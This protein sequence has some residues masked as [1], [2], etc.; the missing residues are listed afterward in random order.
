VVVMMQL[1]PFYDEQAMSLLAGVEE[2]VCR[3]L[4]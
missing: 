3:H 2:I 4:D 1:L